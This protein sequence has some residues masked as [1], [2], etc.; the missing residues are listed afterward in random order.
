MAEGDT[1]TDLIDLVAQGLAKV[2]GELP[3]QE[4]VQGVVG[5]LEQNAS[6]VCRSLDPL[7]SVKV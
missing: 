7:V 3:R 2:P 5:E 1:M 4:I 6:D